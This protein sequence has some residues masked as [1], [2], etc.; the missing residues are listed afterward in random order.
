MNNETINSRLNADLN[1]RHVSQRQQG[2]MNL[3]YLEAWFVID[4]MNQIF[5]FTAWDRETQTMLEFAEERDG[6][7]YVTYT[8]KCIITVST[9]SAQLTRTGHGVGHGNGIRDKGLALESAMKEAESDAMKRACMTLGNQFG[10]ALYDK[11]QACVVDEGH[12]N[13]F[14]EYVEQ[15]N[16]DTETLISLLGSYGAER[17]E[18]VPQR[19]YKSFTDAI[20]RIQ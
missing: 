16:I 2:T 6:K 8:A 12:Q 3:S 20:K 19:H 5:G 10:L 18:D 9:S 7:F 17:L 1:S 14:I 4:Q 15:A 11:A 13:N